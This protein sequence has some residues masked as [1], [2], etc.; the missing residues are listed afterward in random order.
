MKI[1]KLALIASLIGTSVV[2][3]SWVFG[4]GKS[5]GLRILNLPA[6]C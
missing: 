5:S 2:L 4:L 3:G 6:F 1:L